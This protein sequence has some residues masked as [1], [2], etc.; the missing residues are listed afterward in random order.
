MHRKFLFALA[1]MVVALTWMTTGASAQSAAPVTAAPA[2]QTA[3]AA[4]A[5]DSPFANAL[6]LEG[7]VKRT[8]VMAY[9]LMAL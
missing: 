8:G 6:T 2:S 5:E 7:F 9:P 1:L 4:P 3:G